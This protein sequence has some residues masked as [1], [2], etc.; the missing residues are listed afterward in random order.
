MAVRLITTYLLGMVALV[1]SQ[2]NIALI[3]RLYGSWICFAYFVTLYFGVYP[4]ADV[5]SI[6]A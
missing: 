2:L 4:L 6:G 5:R 1:T 3:S